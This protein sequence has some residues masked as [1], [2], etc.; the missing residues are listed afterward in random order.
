MRF[1]D[2]RQPVGSPARAADTPGPSGRRRV[3]LRL[4]WTG[5]LVAVAAVLAWCY[6]LQS[7]TIAANADGASQVLQGQ[8]M[9]HGNLLLSGWT[10]SDVSFY[11]LEVPLDAVV[12]ALHGFGPD[13]V[14]VT[15]AVLYALLVVLAALVARGTARGREGIIRALIAAVI[16]LA[17]GLNTGTRVLLLQPDHT[18]TGVPLLIAM[19]YLDRAR[20][21]WRTPVVLGVLLIWAQVSDL[22]A[23]V[24]GAATVTVTCLI[25]AVSA[26]RQGTDRWRYEA[27]LAV[28]AA[29]S[30]GLAKLAQLAITAAGG[31]ALRPLAGWHLAALS[32]IPRQLLWTGQNALLLFGA[33]WFHLTRGV[34]RAEAF[35]HLAGVLMAVAGLVLGVAAIFRRGDRVTQTLAVGILLVLTAAA[36][37]NFAAPVEGAHEMAVVL[38]FGAALAGRTLGPVLARSGTK[39]M[40]RATAAGL[41]ALAV[42]Y[43]AALGYNA[44]QPASPARAYALAS[45]LEAHHLTSGVSGYWVANITTLASGGHVHV[46]PV[47]GYKKML[48]RRWESKAS[49]FDPATS[50][51]NFAITSTPDNR[52]IR[53]SPMGLLKQFGPPVHVY[54]VGIYKVLTWDYNIL[55]HLG[56]TQPQG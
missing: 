8:E 27:L 24:A 28:A 6:L 43:L 39:V 42:C 53:L 46:V 1:G 11:T 34:P 30:A 15:A 23:M 31:Y 38:P 36:F 49:W 12:T 9:L 54:H 47:H 50:T 48:P 2:T 52:Q 18:G 35:V 32:A 17:P 29:A 51:A 44:S 21:R 20:E 45:F 41:A 33:D 16:L 3:R 5:V 19:L 25:R 7:R 10:L 4:A 26:R 37:G 14:H 56:H 55:T 22:L 13:V 40:R